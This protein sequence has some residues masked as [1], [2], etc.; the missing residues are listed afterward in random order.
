MSKVA[1]LPRI[2]CPLG[3]ASSF[4]EL[5]VLARGRSMLVITRQIRAARSLLGWEQLQL[6]EASGVAIST[7]R[8]IEG[9][10]GQIVARMRTVDKLR[11]AF[12]GAGVEFIGEPGPGVRLIPHVLDAQEMPEIHAPSA[13]EPSKA[14]VC[15]AFV[16]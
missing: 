11:R 1:A 15:C 4:A 6:A 7:I 13:K 12:E 5:V 3:A 16:S 8:R 9:L 2:K 10:N 14:N